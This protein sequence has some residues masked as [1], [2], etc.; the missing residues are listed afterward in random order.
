MPKYKLYTQG[1]KVS[2]RAI[3]GKTLDSGGKLYKKYKNLTRGIA[4]YTAIIDSPPQWHVTLIIPDGGQNL[5]GDIKAA[6]LLLKAFGKKFAKKFPDGWFLHK[7]EFASPTPGMHLHILAQLEKKMSLETVSRGFAGWWLKIT[8][9]DQSELCHVEPFS[10]NHYGYL[11][12]TKKRSDTMFL[13][14]LMNGQH[15][16][17]VANKKA[18]NIAAPQEY[19]VTREEF[20]AFRDNLAALLDAATTTES[21]RVYL[22]NDNG[23]LYYVEPTVQKHALKSIGKGKGKNS[24]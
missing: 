18:V 21:H 22:D 10:P 2:W 12:A 14:S 1:R 5:E 6:K 9:S 4:E 11:T 7:L 19:E 3:N 24:K 23:S 17:G 16:W 13:L 20:D 15:I 8:G